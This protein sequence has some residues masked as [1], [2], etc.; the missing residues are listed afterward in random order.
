[1]L[2]TVLGSV[3]SMSKYLFYVAAFVIAMR[4]VAW[5]LKSRRGY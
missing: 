5:W 3:W 1:M 2:S 4:A